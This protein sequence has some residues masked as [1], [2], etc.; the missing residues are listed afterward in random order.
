MSEEKF[1]ILDD[2]GKP[3][4]IATRSQVHARG[5]WHR[6]A[7]VFLFRSDGRLVLQRRQSSKDVCPD[8]WD[9]SVAEH[10]MPGE[11]YADGAVRGLREELGLGP[12]PL[13]ALG[14]PL[15]FKLDLPAKRIRDYE[16]QQIFRGEF[17]GPLSPDPAEVA[18]VLEIELPALEREIRN[19]P[20]GFTPWF[21]NCAPMIL[22][23]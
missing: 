5:L 18:A 14:E 12:I 22:G 4:G 3:I 8:A 13:H 7:H 11:S 10:L 19:N 17:D 23:V 6:A 21:L 20:G 9:L 1:E 15:R 2:A 16:F